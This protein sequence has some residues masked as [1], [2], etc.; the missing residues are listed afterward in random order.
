MKEQKLRSMYYKEF[1]DPKTG[2]NEATTDLALTLTDGIMECNGDRSK[3]FDLIYE[4]KVEDGYHIWKGWFNAG[5]YKGYA[6]GIGIGVVVSAAVGIGLYC[7]K[8]LKKKPKKETE[9]KEN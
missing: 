6:Q 3:I 1:N 8:K 5:K 7:K 2:M 4:N 9:K